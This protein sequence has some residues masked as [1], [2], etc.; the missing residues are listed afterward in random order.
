[1][2]AQM[3]EEVQRCIDQNR[4]TKDPKLDI[5]CR[6]LREIPE[7]IFDLKHLKV[8]IAYTP[9]LLEDYEPKLNFM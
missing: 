6:G 5:S 7:A 8:C 1:M 4:K 9:D 3:M 2:N